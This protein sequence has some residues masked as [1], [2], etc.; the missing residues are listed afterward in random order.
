MAHKKKINLRDY[1]VQARITVQIEKQFFSQA[2]MLN[3]FSKPK[4]IYLKKD[5]KLTCKSV[6]PKRKIAS[7]KHKE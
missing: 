2:I 5:T 7:L 1:S 6:L 3:Y 4:E